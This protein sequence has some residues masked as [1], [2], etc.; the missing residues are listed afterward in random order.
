MNFQDA[1][2]KVNNLKDW[3]IKI[4]RDIHE[5]P[6]LAMEEYITK[7]KI[8]KYL[9]RI[10]I[11][12]KE[13]EGHRGIIAYIIKNPAYKTIAIRAD[14]D[15]L[16][17][18][19]KNNKL[20]KS[21]H[22]G[23]MHACGHDAHTAM[24]IGACKVLYDMREELKVNVKFFFQG[25]EERFGGA[26]YLIKDGCL[27]KPKVDYMFG[28]HVQANVEKGFIECREGTLNASSSSLKIRI[29]GKRAHG[30][31]PENG[32]DALVCAAQIIT[33][34]Q[35]IVSRNIS[36]SNM[37]VLTLGKIS[38]G[39]A[40]NVICEDVEINGTIRTLNDE[41]KKLIVDRAKTIVENTANAY[42]C[43][44]NIYM[45]NQGYPPVIN[46][47]ELVDIIKFNTEKLLGK[48]AYKEKMYPSMGA[49]D[50]SFYTENCK[51][52]FFHLGCGNKEKSIN[53][54]IHTDTFDI[55]EECL[56]IGSAMHV[57]NVLYFNH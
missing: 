38:G 27:E 57:L 44:G 17:I 6:E 33:S 14:I 34:L 11:E 1:I 20:Y 36:P 5:T 32:T 15:A 21:K 46:D 28:L 40:Q 26:K 47:K 9:D 10:G 3:I 24:L 8:K 29:K 23:V 50:F 39:E 13:F 43:E 49:E 30:A 2:N 31:Y 41:S 4:R 48:E 56:F 22:D 35:S 45:E 54:L 19:E 18:N 37:A 12:Y 42:G 25:A 7:E 55:D 51:G 16:P 53:S 52:V